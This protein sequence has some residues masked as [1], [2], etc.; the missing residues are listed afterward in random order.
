MSDGIKVRRGRWGTGGEI[1]LGV[2]RYL[3]E[4][5]KADV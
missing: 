1:F 4:E 3:R 2:G 5:K